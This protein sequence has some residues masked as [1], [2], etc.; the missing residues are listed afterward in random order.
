MRWNIQPVEVRGVLRQTQQVAGEFEGHVTAMQ[1]SMQGAAGEAS[2]G[3]IAQ[4]L[5]GFAQ[6]SGQD[7]QFVFARTSAALTGASQAVNAY[8][9]GD[10]EMVLNAQQ[11]A[12]AAPDPGGQMPGGGPR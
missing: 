6:S 9:Q 12:A 10:H 8:L 7:V 1:S 11:Q 3:I 4:A 5:Q 2:S